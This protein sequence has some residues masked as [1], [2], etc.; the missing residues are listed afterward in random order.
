MKEQTNSK[1]REGKATTI[2]NTFSRETSISTTIYADPAIVWALLT[3]GADFP[4]WNSTV[5]SIKG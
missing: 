3:H 4:R 2:R 1:S 5:T